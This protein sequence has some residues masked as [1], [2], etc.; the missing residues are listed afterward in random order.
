M[1][2]VGLDCVL[3]AFQPALPM[4]GNDD[5]EGAADSVYV[6]KFVLV[7]VVVNRVLSKL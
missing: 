4:P 1:D 7:R 3:E 2:C 6:T 5:C